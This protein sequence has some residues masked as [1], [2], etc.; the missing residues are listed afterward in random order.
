MQEWSPC[1]K[2]VNF[3]S[4][5]VYTGHCKAAGQISRMFLWKIMTKNLEIMHPPFDLLLPE[6]KA[7][8]DEKF[9]S[10]PLT[11][12]GGK[13]EDEEG[14]RGRGR[15]RRRPS[16]GYGYIGIFRAPRA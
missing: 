5:M 12:G 11:E 6:I 8:R 2:T 1:E 7:V 13:G 14:E 10:P 4:G 9:L 3:T 15:R 16:G